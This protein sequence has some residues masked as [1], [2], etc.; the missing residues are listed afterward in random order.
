VDF[1]GYIADETMAG[2]VARRGME[3]VTAPAGS[4]LLMKLNVRPAPL[5]EPS[6]EALNPRSGPS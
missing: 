1:T 5:I 4:L 2:V 3:S 6:L